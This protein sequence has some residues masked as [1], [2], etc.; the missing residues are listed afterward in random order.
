L[1]FAE[2]QGV[3]REFR[4]TLSLIRQGKTGAE[5]EEEIPF[6]ICLVTMLGLID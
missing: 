3:I 5:L 6:G 1:S 2:K 4:R